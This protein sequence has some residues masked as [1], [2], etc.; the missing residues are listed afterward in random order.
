VTRVA[1]GTS[2]LPWL[3]SRPIAHRGLHDRTLGI[4]ENTRS[5]FAAAVAGRYAIE[6]D[7]QITRDGEAVV[8]HDDHLDRLTEGHG[9]V[10]RQTLA[11]LKALAI[12]DSRDRIQTLA[13]LLEQVAGSVP[14]VIEIKSYWDGSETLTERAL[15]VLE[16]YAGPHCLMSFDPDIVE[17]VRKLSPLTVRGIVADRTT[18]AEYSG[19][20][21]ARRLEMRSLSHVPRTRPHFVS[22][23]QGELPWTPVTTF[24]NA[25]NPVI[26]WTIRNPAQSAHALRYSDQVTFEGYKA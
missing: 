15:K 5:A 7:L 10:R 20:S 9:L 25:G 17:A 18:H 4:I 2:A 24:R 3:V 26:S 23:Y 22:F 16:C 14:L 8:F 19:L 21:V 12:K 1:K 13:E 11:Q 6:C